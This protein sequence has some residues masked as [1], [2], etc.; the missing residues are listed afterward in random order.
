MIDLKSKGITE[1]G[2]LYVND[3]RMVISRY[4]NEGYVET[5]EVLEVGKNN[6]AEG[7]TIRVDAVTKGR[8]KKWTYSKNI[9]LFG[10][11]MHDWSDANL[12]VK[13][14]DAE[15]GTLSSTWNDYYGITAERRYY[16]YNLLE[17]LDAPG[18]WYLDQEEGMLYVYP[19]EPMEKVEFVTFDQPFLRVNNANNVLIK[20]IHFEK[21]IGKGIVATDVVNFV[22]DGCELSSITDTAVTITQSESNNGK[23]S[24]SGVKNSHLHDLGAGGVYINAGD[25]VNLIH[26]ECFVT[27]THIERFSQIK[28]TY[29][30]G[31]YVT[32]MG[33]LINHNE[34]NDA[35]H[36]AIEYRGNNAIME[37]NDIYRV[38]TDTA[39]SGAV[40]TGRDWS[41]RGNE[42]R[43]NYF[44]DMKMIGTKTGMR[45]QAVY[46]D[47]MHSSTKVNGN[48]FY[49]VSSIALFGGG[50][51]NT[52]TNNLMLESDDA[53]RFDAR[54]I[55]W[56]DETSSSGV[57]I[58]NSLNAMPYKEKPWS[59]TYPELVSI[60][61]DEPQLPKYN[62]IKNNVTY[63]TPE[64]IL[65]Q[66]VITYGTVENNISVGNTKDFTDYKNQDFSLVADGTILKQIPDFEIVDYSKIG[67][68]EVVEQDADFEEEDSFKTII[69]TIGSDQMY[70]G[71]EVVTLDVPAQVVND[72]TLVPLRAIFEALGATVEWDENIK[73]V[74]SVKDDITIKLTIGS[75]K[76][77]KNGEET[78]L[79]VPAQV[80]NDRTLVPVRAVSEGF[81]CLVEWIAESEQ[82][83]IHTT[84][85]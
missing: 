76:L 18:E 54:G 42:I 48:I 50:R 24:K 32:G 20:N 5:G 47:D 33:A 49:K 21:G 7:W 12:G 74:T 10:Y 3:K 72:R 6:S 28:T 45:M 27:N 81:G 46:L 63:K 60:L 39:D 37:Y 16:Y 59:E 36:F 15:K 56:M 26:S 66:N 23:T 4:P 30:A 19:S 31:V 83:M 78:V 29:T 9:M 67:R 51:Y 70:Q 41:T 85:K 43:Y 65:D 25:R 73:T 61:E 35:P 2:T 84:G 69:L 58:R 34:I 80:I 8:M 75:D 64:M 57:Q 1:N 13:E 22:V 44:H 38:C 79:D 68:Y 14:F 53:F 62:V 11:F 82:V 40:Y 52:F 17:E 71:D 77:Y 55:T